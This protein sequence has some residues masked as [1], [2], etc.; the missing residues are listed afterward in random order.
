MELITASMKCAPT[1]SPSNHCRVLLVDHGVLTIPVEFQYE[2]K[3]GKDQG[4]NGA[5]GVPTTVH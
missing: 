3:D 4:L 2:D 5:H 1:L